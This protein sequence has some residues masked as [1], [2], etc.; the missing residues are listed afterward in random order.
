MP[1]T[2]WHP[3]CELGSSGDLDPSAPSLNFWE[4]FWATFAGGLAA[5]LISIVG[6]IIVERVRARQE[7]EREA[8]LAVERRLE[9]R[10]ISRNAAKAVRMELFATARPLERF[11][12]GYAGWE[13]MKVRREAW[14][15]QETRTALIDLLKDDALLDI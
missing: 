5:A 12:G 4:T 15:N 11:V 9:R 14:D 8:R 6:I 7:R 10:R 3:D 13:P 1:D 2:E